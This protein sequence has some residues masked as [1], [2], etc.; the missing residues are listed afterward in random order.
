MIPVRLHLGS[1][2]AS[3]HAARNKIW[4]T[5]TCMTGPVV[6]KSGKINVV[7]LPQFKELSNGW[8]QRKKNLIKIVFIFEGEIHTFCP[9]SAYIYSIKGVI[10]DRDGYL[11]DMFQVLS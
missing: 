4:F 6:N 2:A 9:N 11:V 5:H 8:M 3:A 1:A 10:S 7:R